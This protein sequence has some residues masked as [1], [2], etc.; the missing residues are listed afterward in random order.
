MRRWIA[1]FAA[2]LALAGATAGCTPLKPWQRGRLVQRCMQR[3][4][5]PLETAMDL[6]VF[7]T[8]EAILGAAAGGGASCGCN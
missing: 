2:A 8:R 4:L 6:H 1:I 3:S 5:D 7:R